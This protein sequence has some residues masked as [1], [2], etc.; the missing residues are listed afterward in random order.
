LTQAKGSHDILVLEFGRTSSVYFEV[1]QTGTPVVFSW[2]QNGKSSTWVG[3]VNVVSK[4]SASQAERVLKIICVGTS[5]VLKAKSARVFKNSTVSE[6][7]E[8]I[9][10]QFN[11]KFVGD[12]TTRRFESLSVAGQSY[13]E[14]LQEQA[15]RIGYVVLVRNGVMFFRPVDKLIDT[16]MSN[17]AVLVSAPPSTPSDRQVFD[18]TLDSFTVLNGDYLDH[19]SI[20]QRSSR[21]TAGVNPVTGALTGSRATPNNQR[22]PFRRNQ[23]GSLFSDFSDE[24]VHTSLSAKQAAAEEARA[25]KFSVVA[26]VIGQGDPHMFPYSTV[27]IEGTG[28]ETDGYWVTSSVTHKLSLTGTYQMESRVLSDGLGKTTTTPFRRADGNVYGT[29]N[30]N[31]P[32]LGLL[33][34]KSSSRSSVRLVRKVPILVES[35]QGFI[36][37]GTIWSGR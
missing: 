3:Y 35:Q 27:L 24:V 8:Q 23:S 17:S 29:V 25:R 30:L 12:P 18:R 37:L 36:K 14:W 33:D 32:V 7:A 16:F 11:F 10:K 28:V 2:N 9:A 22:R 20:M 1:L 19:D 34:P 15:T 21:V 31:L 26:Q 4:Q 13:W 5:F 6:A